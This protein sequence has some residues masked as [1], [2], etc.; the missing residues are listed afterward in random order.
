[1]VAADTGVRRS[2]ADL[3]GSRVEGLP[4][5]RRAAAKKLSSL[6]GFG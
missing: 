1:V 4:A 3:T 6:L 5:A 2:A